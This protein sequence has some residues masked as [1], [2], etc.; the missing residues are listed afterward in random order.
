MAV[1]VAVAA[2]AGEAARVP[3]S[4]TAVARLAISRATAQMRGVAMVVAVVVVAHT[5]A[6]ATQVSAAEARP[7]TPAVVLGT[8]L[9]TVCKAA[10]VTTAAER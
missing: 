10:S 5:A 3:L 1:A 4:A 9:G 6:E 8:S 7:A 2:V